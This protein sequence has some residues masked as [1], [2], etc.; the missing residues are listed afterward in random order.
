MMSERTQVT[1]TT[2]D[3]RKYVYGP[4]MQPVR[5]YDALV[6]CI[7]GGPDVVVHEENFGKYT[8]YTTADLRS[9]E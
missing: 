2:K 4:G 1:V 9:V 8:R 3:G 5:L 6:K 7:N